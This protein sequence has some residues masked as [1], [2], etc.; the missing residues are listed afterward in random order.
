MIINWSSNVY[1]ILSRRHF[2]IY[3]YGTNGCIKFSGLATEIRF[4]KRPNNEVQHEI[5][6]GKIPIIDQSY[7][8]EDAPV[9]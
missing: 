2:R 6:N 9:I 1:E 4:F 3:L 8:H 5:L 7:S